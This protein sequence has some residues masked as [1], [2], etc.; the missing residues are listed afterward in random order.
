MDSRA[1]LEQHLLD[2][3]DHAPD[4]HDL[5]AD[6]PTIYW[7]TQP[8][9]G[10]LPIFRWPDGTTVTIG[11]GDTIIIQRRSSRQIESPDS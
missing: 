2:R 11:R 9:V 4:R 3:L 5:P 6:T 8:P 7:A 10:E 1:R